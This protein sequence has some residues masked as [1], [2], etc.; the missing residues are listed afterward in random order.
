MSKTN[1]SRVGLPGAEFTSYS[2]ELCRSFE[3]G[4][5]YIQICVACFKT[6]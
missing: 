1:E 3:Q 5:W 2:R 4:R 6:I